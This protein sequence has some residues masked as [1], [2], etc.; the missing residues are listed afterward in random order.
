VTSMKPG[1]I[2]LASG[3]YVL[4]MMTGCAAYQRQLAVREAASSIIVT[5]GDI[6]RQYD[7]LGTIQWP[8]A[9]YRMAFG[10]PCTPEILREEAF[11]RWGYSVSAIIGYTS[12]NDSGQIQCSGTAVR[13]R[14]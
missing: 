6:N 13:F 10:T 9:G 1:V 11:T 12:W 14:N 8:G 7:I 2:A 5:P 4:V 3:L